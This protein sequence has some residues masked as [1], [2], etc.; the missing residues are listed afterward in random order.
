MSRELI[1]SRCVSV[2]NPRGCAKRFFQ[3]AFHLCGKAFY[4]RLVL[5]N[6]RRANTNGAAIWFFNKRWWQIIYLY[7]GLNLCES[8]AN[9]EH[10]RT[11]KAEF[12]YKLRTVRADLALSVSPSYIGTSPIF[13]LVGAATAT[14]DSGTRMVMGGG[15]FS[16]VMNAVVVSSGTGLRIT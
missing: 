4:S 3:H 8:L 14:V 13:C 11:E 2:K 6:Q 15:G 10:M 7:S 16:R 9:F 5:L 12:S 1:F